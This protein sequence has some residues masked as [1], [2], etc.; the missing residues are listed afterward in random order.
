MPAA[1]RTRKAA[2]ETAEAEP[3][4]TSRRR[5]RKAAQAE[6]E[7]AKASNGNR[8]THEDI[9]A[10]VPEIVEHLK[11]GVTMTEIRLGGDTVA[12]SGHPD[13]YGAGPV[14]RKALTEA[15][16]NTKGESIDRPDL[17]DLEGKALADAVAELREDGKAWYYIELAADM[18]QDDL[19]DL[20]EENGYGQLA[21][22][23]VIISGSDEEEEEAPAPTT[24][25][26]GR[27]A[28]Q[29]EE[30]PAPAATTRRRGR[31]AAT[32]EAE[33]EPAAATTTRRRRG[34]KAE[35]PS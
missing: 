14:I 33:P 26:R 15:G 34:R 20:L 18:S 21:E 28:A 10:L 4:T 3:Q 1:R 30:E 32:A 27:K 5:G 25:R 22:G 13:G 8:R 2:A 11:N 9:V 16:F 17:S 24:R 35:N 7:P 6:P 23:R 12:K 31:K 19:K 29:A